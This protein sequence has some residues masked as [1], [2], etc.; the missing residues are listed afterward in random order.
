[1]LLVM[2]LGI[3]ADFD[4]YLVYILLQFPPGALRFGEVLL[5]VRGLLPDV[6]EHLQFLNVENLHDVVYGKL[7]RDHSATL[8]VQGKCFLKSTILWQ[9]LFLGL[10]KHFNL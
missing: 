3:L 7:I 5:V 9:S 6:V 10:L 1:M 4:P 8:K 2:S